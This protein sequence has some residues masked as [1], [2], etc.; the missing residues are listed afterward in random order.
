MSQQAEFAYHRLYRSQPNYRWWR[1]LL[2]LLLSG[3]LLVVV[4]TT[5]GLLVFLSFTLIAGSLPTD[6]QVMTL[7]TPDVA[8]PLSLI[9]SL[10]S[11]AIWIPLI[12]LSLWVVGI[13]PVGMLNSVTFRLRWSHIG[14]Y[15]IAAATVVLLAQAVS[16]AGIFFS[17]DV[18]QKGPEISPV[19]GMLSVLAILLLV[20]FQAAAEEYAFRGIFMQ[21]L[22]SWIKH[23]A[24]PIILPT[25]LFMLG[26]S[27]D[28]W[29]MAEVFL[30]GITAA[31][32]TYKTGGLEAAIVI[33]VMNNAI[34]F[35]VLLTGV[36]GVTAVSYDAGSPLSLILSAVMLAGYSFWVLRIARKNGYVSVRQQLD[37]SPTEQHAGETPQAEQS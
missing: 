9:L 10:V 12:F 11:V 28:V 30:M 6:E 26:H 34:L 25:A 37:E 3:V 27:Y 35:L 4:S 18:P 19:N 21:T 15:T 31:W 24:I 8:N 17:G 14:R 1:P 36:F 16:V 33:H 22:G 29:G 5:F 32:L 23:P 7:V 2:A 20:P 13:K